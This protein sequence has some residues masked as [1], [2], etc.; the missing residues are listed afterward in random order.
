[1]R[2]VATPVPHLDDETPSTDAL[3]RAAQRGDR[4]A[5]AALYERHA[6]LVQ[7][8][9]LAS[10]PPDD[11]SDLLQ[12]VFLTALRELP[13]LRDPAA[14]GGWLIQIARNAARMHLRSRRP[15]EPLDDAVHR[16]VRTS[17]DSPNVGLDAQLDAERIMAHV[18]A[19]PVKLREPLL[20]RLV[21]GMSGE[22]IA[23]ATGLTHG[24]VR[25]YLHEGMRSLRE[26]LQEE[27][28]R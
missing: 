17:D 15:T 18:R 28:R 8:V 13:R 22:E 20:L 6:R 16:D 27:R 3:V 25:V 11:A 1:V 10:V 26:R 7:A 23:R 5:F 4:D 12:E 19:L 9:L 14:F 21:E 2:G 24:T